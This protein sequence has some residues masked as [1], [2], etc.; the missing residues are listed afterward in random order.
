MACLQ[1]T[2]GQ[3]KATTAGGGVSVSAKK[4]V[5][6]LSRQIKAFHDQVMASSDSE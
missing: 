3:L 4:K 6:T 2:Q 1:D 5:Q